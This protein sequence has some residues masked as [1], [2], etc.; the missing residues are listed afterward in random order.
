M[1]DVNIIDSNQPAR[2]GGEVK[3]GHAGISLLI[4]SSLHTN[5]L[6]LSFRA[7][8][9][10]AR[11]KALGPHRRKIR[12]SVFRRHSL[13]AGKPLRKVRRCCCR[14]GGLSTRHLSLHIRPHT[15]CNPLNGCTLP[16]VRGSGEDHDRLRTVDAGRTFKIVEASGMAAATHVNG[17]GV[18]GLMKAPA[19]CWRR[20]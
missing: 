12:L 9:E 16:L 13:Q 15:C 1:R 3:S 10:C 8:L 4:G 11:N 2:S 5:C 6:I 18:A 14:P 17:K 20:L 19:N 7:Q